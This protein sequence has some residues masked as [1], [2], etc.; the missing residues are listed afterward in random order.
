MGKAKARE[1][2]RERALSSDAP[3]LLV[4]GSVKLISTAPVLPYFIPLLAF[5]LPFITSTHHSPAFAAVERANGVKVADITGKS[6]PYC[7]VTVN[8][9]RYKTPK[10]HQ[11]LDPVW[12]YVIPLPSATPDA[13]IL[14]ECWDW[15]QA[16]LRLLN[17]TSYTS[18]F[19]IIII[20]L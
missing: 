5:L 11:T 12:N 16:R 4:P 19:G 9:T 6:D 1:K 13:H 20:L 18:Y 8:G 17:A 10:V 3:P 15:D 7:K 2:V 14:L